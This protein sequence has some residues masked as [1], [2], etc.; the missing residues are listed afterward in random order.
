MRSLLQPIAQQLREGL[1]GER[2][3]LAHVVPVRFEEG[4]VG[5]TLD[6][7]EREA[8]H[9]ADEPRRRQHRQHTV[10]PPRQH[11]APAREAR[12]GQGSSW[13]A[14]RRRG[15]AGRVRVD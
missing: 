11:E 2:V 9:E 12:V 10:Q 4:R 3:D 6:A 1:L 13:R 15:R 14:R 7:E 5:D 8:T